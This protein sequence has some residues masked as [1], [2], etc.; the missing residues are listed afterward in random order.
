MQ[1]IIW[2]IAGFLTPIVLVLVIAAIEKWH[3]N[4]D[5]YPD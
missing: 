4:D 5:L 2:Y 1:N 3:G